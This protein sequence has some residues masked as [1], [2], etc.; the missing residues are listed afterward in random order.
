MLILEK[1]NLSIEGYQPLNTRGYQP[2]K[3]TSAPVK[4]SGHQ[5]TT[6]H[7]QTDSISKKEPPRSR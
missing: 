3:T 2:Q 5:P 4:S 7:T 1:R 6:S